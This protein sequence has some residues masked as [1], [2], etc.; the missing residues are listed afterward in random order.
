MFPRETEMVELF[1]EG[2]VFLLL[3]DNA[4]AI[5]LGR[6]EDQFSWISF[7]N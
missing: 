6:T 3:I 2:S 5:I 7:R 1:Y 4:K